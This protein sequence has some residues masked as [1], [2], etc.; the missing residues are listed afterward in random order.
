MVL[1]LINVNKHYKQNHALR[2]FSYRF[3]NGIYGLLGPKGAGKSTLINY[4]VGN[5]QGDIGSEIICNDK[6]VVSF[7]KEY[8]S[9]IGFMPQQ[10]A[11]YDNFTARHF[12]L[13]IAALKNI[14]SNLACEQTNKL[15]SAVELSDTA[16]KNIGSFSGGMKQRLLVA[17]AILGNPEIVL[18]DE[19]TAGL[20][21]RQRV[22]IRELIKEYSKDRIIIVSTH[23]TSDIESIADEVIMMDKGCVIQSGSTHKLCNSDDREISLEQLYM[24]I[25]GEKGIE[26]S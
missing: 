4:I 19:P 13:Y 16:D 9:K 22:I 8:R 15:L 5:I 26:R 14:S 23:I 10:Q 17:Q 3:H 25:Y 7:N 18:L 20:D 2:N 1:E 12:M 11:L 6:K 24:N 21:P